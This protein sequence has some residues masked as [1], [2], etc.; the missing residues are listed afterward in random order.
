MDSHNNS[1]ISTKD[2]AKAKEEFPGFPGQ[3]GNVQSGKFNKTCSSVDFLF[4]FPTIK[5]SQ[6]VLF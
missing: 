3:G 6:L 2:N 1:A 5:S 4:P